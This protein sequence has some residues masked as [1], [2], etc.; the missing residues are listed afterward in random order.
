MKLPS[1]IE[2]D[3]IIFEMKVQEA[4]GTMR[5][6]KVEI[7]NDSFG[8]IGDE[9][10]IHRRIFVTTRVWAPT[11]EE[12]C[13]YIWAKYQVNKMEDTGVNADQYYGNPIPYYTIGRER[14]LT[15]EAP[16]V[17]E[18]KFVMTPPFFNMRVKEGSA[19]K[20]L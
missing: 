14:M 5:R 1:Q 12:A 11:P 6:Y 15:T 2:K 10:Q 17:G 3:D 18:R 19:T 16:P 8:W 7:Y 13:E 20:C 9:Q 4:I